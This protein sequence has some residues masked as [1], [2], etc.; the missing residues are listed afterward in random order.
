MSNGVLLIKSNGAENNWVQ[1]IEKKKNYI[2]FSIS[3]FIN[4]SSTIVIK[5]K[6]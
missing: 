4:L 2:I 5:K 3:L 1:K 6:T